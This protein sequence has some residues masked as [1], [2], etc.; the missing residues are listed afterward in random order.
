MVSVFPEVIAPGEKAYYYEETTQDSLTEAIDLVILPRAE[1]VA[2]TIDLIR[3]EVT[4]VTITDTDYFGPKAV[5]RVENTT[6]E[7][8]TMVYIT[9]ILFDAADNPIGVLMTIRTDELAPGDKVGFEATSLS[10]PDSITA[11]DVARFEAY[12]YP[13]QFQ[14]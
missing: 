4:D 1:A 3:Y 2:A 5:G 6:D 14:F 9:V 7:A 10:M 8:Q 11:A 13:L 12:S